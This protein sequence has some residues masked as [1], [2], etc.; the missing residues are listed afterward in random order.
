MRRRL[1]TLLLV[2]VTL[3]VAL[4]PLRGAW[5]LPDDAGTTDTESHC[6][7]MQHDMQQMNHHADQRGNTDSQP[8]K[9][10]PGCNGSCCDQGCTAC[11][12]GTAAISASLI[13]LRDSLIHMHGLLLADSVPERHLKPPLR[14]PLA[15]L[16]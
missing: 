9:C 6:A 14:P 4:A 11:L 3:S 1:H 8:H 2:L 16:S 7:G 15:L 5:A 12:H 13:V 10:K